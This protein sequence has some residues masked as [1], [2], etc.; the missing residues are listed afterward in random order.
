LSTDRR[1][2]LLPRSDSG[3]APEWAITYADMITL[4]LIFFIAL[5]SYSSMD[6]AKYRALAA[7]MRQAFGGKDLTSAGSSRT[8]RDAQEAEDGAA[9]SGLRAEKEL[10]GLVASGGPGGPF[11]MLRSAEGL[12]LRV[13]DRLMFGVASAAMAPEAAAFLDKLAPILARYPYR[14]E[15][16]GHTDGLPI[17]NQTYPSNW[18]LSGARAGSVVRELIARGVPAARLSAVGFADTHP[19]ASDDD[20]AGRGRNRRV[21]FLL[22]RKW[23]STVPAQNAADSTATTAPPSSR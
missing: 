21:E 14:V 15:V 12:R 10:G 22:T 20:A 16:Q 18:E 13:S 4:V 6:Q 1:F 7:G 23:E 11:E 2:S 8:V 17:Q 19:L 9:A 5:F 3:S